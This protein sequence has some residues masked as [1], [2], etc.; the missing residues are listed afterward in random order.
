MIKPNEIESYLSKKPPCPG[1]IFDES[2]TL[3]N[4]FILDII[5]SP[6]KADIESSKANKKIK[7][8]LFV[9]LKI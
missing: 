4:L 7:N 8:K 9:L 5:K 2:L 6:T 3:K 1:N